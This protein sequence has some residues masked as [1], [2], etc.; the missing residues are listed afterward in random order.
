MRVFRLVLFICCVCVLQLRAD[1]TAYLFIEGIPGEVA[2]RSHQNWIAVG[3]FFEEQVA[4]ITTPGFKTSAITVSKSLDKASPLLAL[5]AAKPATIPTAHLQFV[6][7]ADN[8]AFYDLVLSN[9]TITQFYQ[10]V[11]VGSSSSAEFFTLNFQNISWTYTIETGG[12][13]KGTVSTQ[14]NNSQTNGSVTA[15]VYQGNG[16]TSFGGAIGGGT[17]EFT[18]DATTIYGTLTKGLG[19]FTDVLVLYID[20]GIAGFTD[21]SGFNDISD[22]LRRAVSGTD[23][24]GETSVLTFT[25]AS[26]PFTP[27][28]A[29][30]LSPASDTSG[31]VFKLA[32]GGT[33]SLMNVVSANLVPLGTGTSPTYTFSFPISQIGLPP[34]AGETFRFLGTYISNNG[35][36]SGETVGGDVSGPTGWNPFST[37]SV[38]S[39]TIS[40]PAP[41]PVGLTITYDPQTSSVKFSWPVTSVPYALQQNADLGSVD[42]T[43]VTNNPTIVSN[44][45]QVVVSISDVAAKFYRLKY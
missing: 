27:S 21:T 8:T 7:T 1:Y 2:D 3:S 39:Y 33:G 23:S 22:G 32:N 11:N 40:P 20:N 19:D 16:D 4:S 24:P 37:T 45:N 34:Y 28:Y 41:S 31:Q 15:A 9:I 26:T 6:N 12:T 17:L 36:R 14:W 43:T 38:D 13:V 18:N 25:N 42:W 44:Q 10:S 5:Q 30:A 29:V 35:Y